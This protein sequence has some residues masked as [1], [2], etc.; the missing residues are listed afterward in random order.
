MGK[1]GSGSTRL[2]AH[3]DVSGTAPGHGPFRDSLGKYPRI[4]DNAARIARE[5][6]TEK[7]EAIQAV[8]KEAMANPALSFGERRQMQIAN[9][10]LISAVAFC[11]S[12]AKMGHAP[13]LGLDVFYK[14]LWSHLGRF[15]EN[16]PRLKVE[17]QGIAGE[18]V[19]LRK[20]T[21]PYLKRLRT[22]LHTLTDGERSDLERHLNKLF[23]QSGL[24]IGA[25]R[26]GALE[27]APV[28]AGEIAIKE[29]GKLAAG[30]AMVVVG[31]VATSYISITG[32]LI[33]L[34]E[35]LG[36]S[37]VVSLGGS[38]PPVFATLVGAAGALRYITHQM[39]TSEPRALAPSPHRE[40]T[41]GEIYDNFGSQAAVAEMFKRGT[42]A[43]QGMARWLW[44]LSGRR[45]SPQ[46]MSTS[47]GLE[48]DFAK[49][50]EL[51]P[52]RPQTKRTVVFALAAT[53]GLTA[54]TALGDALHMLERQDVYGLFWALVTIVGAFL[55]FFVLFKSLFGS[56]SAKNP[57]RIANHSWIMNNE[58]LRRYGR[59]KIRGKKRRKNGKNGKRH[60][61]SRSG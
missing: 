27:R 13:D 51:P 39:L 52:V 38:S 20:H 54:Y 46:L 42:R 25:L 41:V 22:D 8:F 57:P 40:L 12:V 45:P 59:R 19:R 53:A 31:S 55:L 48:V 15:R 33:A 56:F 50:K 32:Q 36:V 2:T 1:F 30:V 58:K 7:R 61:K 29:K 14:K 17:T 5:L 21:E 34:M 44:G 10:F 47:T 23:R 28:T 43:S 18:I 3:S 11:D 6:P 35:A 24:R 9:D 26:T 49:E 16:L 60:K 37:A 4:H